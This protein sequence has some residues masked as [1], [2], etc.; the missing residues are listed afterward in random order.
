MACK[1]TTALTWPYHVNTMPPF[2]FLFYLSNLIETGDRK[3]ND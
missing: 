3:Q 2:K 1:R